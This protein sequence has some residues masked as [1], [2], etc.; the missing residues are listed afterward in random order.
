MRLVTTLTLFNDIERSFN[1]IHT[2]DM[3]LIFFN[4]I[5]RDFDVAQ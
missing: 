1:I 4:D 3:P 2:L 5:R